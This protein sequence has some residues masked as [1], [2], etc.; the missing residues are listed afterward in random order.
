[1]DNFSKILML[2]K[3]Y[4]E[5]TSEFTDSIRKGKP[6][7]ELSTI[8]DKAKKVAEDIKTLEQQD[9]GRFRN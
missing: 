1:M 3:K 5:L 9:L 2:R 8:K 7:E 4:I 6:A